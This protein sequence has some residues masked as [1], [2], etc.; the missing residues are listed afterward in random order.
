MKIAI[1]CQGMS[2]DA[3]VDTRFGRC[4]AF[5][6]Y[7]TDTKVLEFIEN[8]N[9]NAVEGA[10]PASVSLIANQNVSKVISGEFGFKIK[11]MLTDLNIQM[12][13]MKENRTVQE[14]INL[15]K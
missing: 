2:E 7:N 12:V 13:I 11:Q 8:P 6:I 4:T 15:I 1:S 9:K 14:I 5:A 3:L 10:G